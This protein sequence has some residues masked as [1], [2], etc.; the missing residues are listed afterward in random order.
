[1]HADRRRTALAV[2]LALPVVLAGCTAKTPADASADGE[3]AVEA[4]DSACTVAR[5]EAAT[6]PSTF[7]ITNSGSSVTE[8]YVYGEGDRVMGEVEN[9]GPGLSRQL[10]VS[11]PQPGT[12]RTA[13]KPGMVGDGIRHDFV[14]TGDA[15]TRDDDGALADAADGYL[16]YVRA[17]TTALRETTGGFVDAVVAG[18]VDSA[19]AQYPLVRTYYERIEPV[20][21]SFPDDLD[22]RLDLREPDV[23]PGDRWTGFHRLEKDLWAQ[24]L[25]PDTA[26]IAEQLRS[27]V[28]ELVRGVDS[29]DFVL[30]PVTVA[31]GAQGLL[32]EVAQTKITGEEDVYSHTDLYD[33]QANV[34]GSQAAVATLDPILR[35]KDA[36]LADTIAARFADLDAELARYRTGETFVSYDT[37]TEPQRQQLS[38]KIDA[39]SASVSRVQGVV[40]GA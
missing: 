37:V 16:R 21:E 20:A 13:C 9:I 18:N 38:Q 17:Q 12:Y 4:T 2:C 28:D 26:E 7:R 5:S 10:V 33:F 39:L 30:D 15:V 22:P 35:A 14:V 6:G 32:D 8:L 40:A 27:D 34:D 3:I 31:G 29:A 24:G 1:M 36:E 23:E 19:K 11:L 25:Q